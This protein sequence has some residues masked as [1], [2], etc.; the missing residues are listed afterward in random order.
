VRERPGEGGVQKGD[1]ARGF[2]LDEA[3]FLKGVHA[4]LATCQKNPPARRLGPAGT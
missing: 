1:R 4:A 3:H 2:G